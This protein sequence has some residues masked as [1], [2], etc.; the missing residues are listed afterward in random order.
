MAV[1]LVQH[2]KSLPKDIDPERSLSD[3]GISEVG[4]IAGVA[5]NYHMKD[6]LWNLNPSEK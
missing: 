1:Y 2:G 4:L 5:A 6:C 3:E